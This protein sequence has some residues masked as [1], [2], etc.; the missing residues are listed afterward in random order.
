MRITVAQQTFIDSLICER[1]SAN[2]Q[3]KTLAN[4]FDNQRNPVLVKMLHEAWDIDKS[5]ESAYYMVK[6]PDGTLLA[7]FSLKCGLL[8][9]TINEEYYKQIKKLFLL[10]FQALC[11]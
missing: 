2:T 3:N 7:Y 10:G 4:T 6:S 8:Y 9:D 1:M 5:N 11:R